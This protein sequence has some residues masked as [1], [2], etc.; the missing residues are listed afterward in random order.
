MKWPLRISPG[1]FFNILIFSVLTLGGAYLFHISA[2]HNSRDSQEEIGRVVEKAGQV[3][4]KP[5]KAQGWQPARDLN[6]VYDKTSLFTAASSR[7]SIQVRNTMIQVDEKT[8]IQ[9]IDPMK[10]TELMMDFGGLRL[11]AK[12]KEQVILNVAGERIR[13]SLDASTVR[14]KREKK[15]HAVKIESVSGPVTVESISHP[16]EVLAAGKSVNLEIQSQDVR[17]I[18]DPPQTEVEKPK[19]K[20]SFQSDYTSDEIFLR[21]PALH[22][23]ILSDVRDARI[24]IRDPNGDWT[25]YENG[26]FIPEREGEYMV[27]AHGTF[28]DGQE[29][30]TE[31]APWNPKNE[32]FQLRQ[33]VPRKT[34]FK[35]DPSEK[36]RNKNLF[37]EFPSKT[38]HV[39]F[40]LDSSQVIKLPAEGRFPAELIPAGAQMVRVSELDLPFTVDSAWSPLKLTVTKPRAQLVDGLVVVPPIHLDQ[41]YYEAIV[42]QDGRSLE[43]NRRHQADPEC[44]AA[45]TIKVRY[46]SHLNPQ[47]SSAETKLKIKTTPASLRALAAELLNEVPV[48]KLKL[49][50]VE[51]KSAAPWIFEAGGGGNY[52]NMST[53]SSLTNA[54]SSGFSG[55]GIFASGEHQREKYNFKASYLG[56]F[57]KMTNVS[58]TGTTTQNLAWQS[59]WAGASQPG[60]GFLKR[61]EYGATF[62]QMPLF[63]Q[64]AAGDGQFQNGNTFAGTIGFNT[65]YGLGPQG[66]LVW[67][68]RL[69]IPFMSRSSGTISSFS[70]KFGVEGNLSYYHCLSNKWALGGSWLGQFWNARF[71]LRE[72]PGLQAESPTTSMFNSN[73]QIRLQYGLC[74]TKA[75]QSN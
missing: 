54:T 6:P 18:E 43:F 32:H 11:S 45:C 68:Q 56:I 47:W 41:Y 57:T 44:S 40:R 33:P 46:K 64:N 53:T 25:T 17:N 63:Y 30:E 23:A 3:T 65:S 28:A 38:K 66:R 55:P 48:E 34:A 27:R 69:L 42:E 61:I 70:P 67:D 8:L 72:E 59:V 26:K 24:E 73:F 12:Q 49:P 29:A 22:A 75:V 58:S 4:I 39:E 9:I 16:E 10:K 5:G 71:S 31:P 21:R 2:N 15:S 60:F 50:P 14:I 37:R 7:A 74:G 51:F 35:V 1:G 13:V 20:L 19:L 62:Q 36:P 52:L